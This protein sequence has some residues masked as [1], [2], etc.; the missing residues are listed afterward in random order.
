MSFFLGLVF[1]AAVSSSTEAPLGDLGSAALRGDAEAVRSLLDRGA[2]F[3]AKTRIGSYTPLHVASRG[4]H[5]PI[6]RMLLEAGANPR[7][8][9]TTSGVTPLHLAAASIGG[10]EAVAELLARGAD[11]N[12][13]EG[14]AGQ[15]PLMFAA[16]SNRAAAVRALLKGGADPG[17]RT[18]VVDVLPSL[19]LDREADERF[20]AMISGPG[21]FEAAVESEPDPD[22]DRYAHSDPLA[23]ELS[24]SEIQAAIRAQREFL[25]S[26]YDAGVV[27]G[28]SLASVQPDYPGG[29]DVV[30]PPF[31]EVLVGKTGGMTALLHAAREGHTEAAKALLEGDAD[32]N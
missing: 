14:S 15:T 12:A 30:R 13:R 20:L 7:A 18:E 5:V 10:G 31:R 23:A 27:D 25:K 9:T 4:G 3:E 22:G 21:K 16:G 32:V 29:P 8:V 19:A 11:P 1:L 26:G 24:G 28:H 6:I 2:D 17:L